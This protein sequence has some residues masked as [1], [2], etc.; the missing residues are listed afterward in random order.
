MLAETRADNS[1]LRSP[2]RKIGGTRWYLRRRFAHRGGD[3]MRRTLSGEYAIQLDGECLGVTVSVQ[4]HAV[5]RPKD[6][7]ETAFYLQLGQAAFNA[8]AR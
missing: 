5:E 7:A 8:T 3:P 2:G 6:S 4:I 1:A